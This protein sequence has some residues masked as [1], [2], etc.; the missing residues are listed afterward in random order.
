MSMYL[1]TLTVFATWLIFK[2]NQV[3]RR[4]PT[5]RYRDLGDFIWAAEAYTGGYFAIALLG[6]FFGP[7]G[8]AMMA[9]ILGYALLCRI[10]GA[11]T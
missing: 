10:R 7:W 5:C 8:L 9:W 6:V 3:S 2:A 4:I 1:I 11:S